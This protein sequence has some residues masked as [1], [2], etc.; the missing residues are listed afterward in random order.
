[1]VTDFQTNVFINCP[2]D[3]EY[4]TLLKPLLFTIVALGFNP[5]IALERADSAEQRISKI[6]ELIGES[7][8]SIHDLSRLKS[9]TG[10]E[11]YRQNMPFELGID[12]GS[13]RFHPGQLQEKRFLI[14]ATTRFEYMRAISDLSGVDIQAHKDQPRILIRKLRNWFY[15]TVGKT[16]I[17]G[18]AKI[19]YAYNDFNT[20]L[21]DKLEDKGFSPEDIQELIMPEFI[22]YV[23]RWVKSF[24][25]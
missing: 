20:D 23:E 6:C 17:P 22:D 10:D 14:L 12:Y 2:F 19:W 24:P 16:D 8:Y 11:Y 21:H 13:R 9:T 25:I 1:M 3:Q 7:K 15:S 18:P 4:K 5:R